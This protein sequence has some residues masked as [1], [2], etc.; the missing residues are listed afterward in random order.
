MFRVTNGRLQT[1]HEFLPTPKNALDLSIAKW[2]FILNYLETTGITPHDGSGDTCGLCV[3]YMGYLCCLCSIGA[4]GY[5]NCEN[6]PYKDY[7][8][9]ITLKEHITAAKAEIT[10]LKGLRK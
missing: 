2:E 3:L 6:T 1:T 9:A 5:K 7:L 8:Y 4:A 10:F